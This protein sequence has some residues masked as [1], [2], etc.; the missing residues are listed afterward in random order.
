MKIRTWFWE[1]GVNG[2][3]ILKEIVKKQSI[4]ICIRYISFIIVVPVAES[5]GHGNELSWSI[6][7][8]KFDNRFYVYQFAYVTQFYNKC[9]QNIEM[10]ILIYLFEIWDLHDLRYEGRIYAFPNFFHIIRKE[11]HYNAELSA[12][13][14]IIFIFREHEM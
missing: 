2:R 9:T 8:F 13:R 10:L 3:I 4:I 7:G 14:T 12:I 1:F 11:N 6:R 5:S